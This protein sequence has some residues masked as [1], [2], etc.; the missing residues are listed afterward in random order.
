[1]RGAERRR[2]GTG[3]YRGDCGAGIRIRIKGAGR[4]DD[5]GGFLEETGRLPRGH[6][7]EED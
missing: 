4:I 2:N 5:A 1:M 7:A 6:E 3:A